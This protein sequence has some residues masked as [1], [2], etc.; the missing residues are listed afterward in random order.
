MQ[1]PAASLQWLE[2]RVQ[3]P[4]F[5]QLNRVVWEVICLTSHTSRSCPA[6]WER[7]Q[8]SWSWDLLLGVGEMAPQAK[9]PAGQ[10]AE[11]RCQNPHAR[12]GK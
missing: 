1:N 8:W 5:P 2:T 10:S 11:H 4:L 3:T 7:C 6:Q 12:G 9:L